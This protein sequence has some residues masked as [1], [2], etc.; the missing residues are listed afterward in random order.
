MTKRKYNLRNRNI[1][2][3]TENTDSG[4]D[5]FSSDYDSDD[6]QEI[7]DI[8]TK[9]NTNLNKSLLEI[10]KEII[11]T[12]PDLKKL[13]NSKFSIKEK[14][15]LLQLYEIY[16]SS[17]INTKEW[18][19]LRNEYIDIF[20]NFKRNQTTKRKFSLKKIQKLNN[21]EQK[22]IFS[23]ANL[24]MK[25][26][27]LNL[28]T[29][30]ENISVIY[31][32]YK[33]MEKLSYDDSEKHKI[34]N[35]LNVVTS[36]PYKNIKELNF[37]SIGMFIKNAKTI[38]DEEL[39]GMV[40]IKEKILLTLLAKI[41]NPSIT[42]TNICLIGPPGVGKTKIARLISKIMDFG[43]SQ[44]SFGGTTKGDFLKGH[45]YTYVGSQAGAITKSITQIG[46]SN[47]V[48]FLDELDKA[49]DN[50]EILSSFLHI[51]DNS[52]NTEYVDLFFGQDLKLDISKIFFI[53]SMNNMINDLPLM[54]RFQ[55]IKIDGYNTKEKL[56]ILIQ[57]VLPKSLTK[58]KLNKDS[59]YFTKENG[60]YFINKIS[61][62]NDKG[63]RT[64]EKE[65][66]DIVN[67]I[68]FLKSLQK[69]DGTIPF[70]VSF[71]M[72]RDIVFPYNLDK[73]TID[74]LVYRQKTNNIL[75]MYI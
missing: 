54:D 47:G 9:K 63:I 16:K 33:E 44:I 39:Y 8:L 34:R 69:K 55:I 19:E 35:W 15:K 41:K 68:V 42:N 22:L 12:E 58:L 29:T 32:K 59:M 30:M 60:I 5:D 37:S 24:D 40:N 64:I 38:L 3:K 23:D 4:D 62:E 26:K 10:R 70:S 74:T 51:L 21:K 71:N 65:T 73:Y 13:L 6:Y 25:Y 49:V 1:L 66:F 36:F 45:E 7:I 17:D 52:Q 50:P 20:D 11:K 56:S 75:P 14:S 2:K 31:R 61:S 72:K 67:K 48:I 28:N 53:A 43:F 57:H 46:T 27:I 18:L